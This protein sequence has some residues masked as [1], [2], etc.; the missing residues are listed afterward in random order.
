MMTF[1]GTGELQ[2]SNRLQCADFKITR[3]RIAS[4][5]GILAVLD[6]ADA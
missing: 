4:R 3:T 2:S 1:D 6:E 5:E